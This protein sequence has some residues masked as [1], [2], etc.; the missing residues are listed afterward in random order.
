MKTLISISNL[1]ILIALSFIVRAQNLTYEW[2]FEGSRELDPAYRIPRKPKIIDTV[3]ARPEVKKDLIPVKKEVNIQ[4]EKIQAA[5]IKVTDKLDQLY[6]GYALVGVGRY[7]MPI[8]EFYYNGTRSKKYH[9]GI[10]AKHHSAWV[11]KIQDFAQP[12]F[13]RTQA[14]LYGKLIEK[15]YTVSSRLNYMNHGVLLYGTRDSLATRDS[16]RQRFQN[17]GGLVQFESHE[18]DSA[19]IN[20]RLGLEYNNYRDKARPELT[21]EWRARENY[22]GIYSNFRYK[23]DQ[24][25]Y[26]LNA[27]IQFN[28]YKFGIADSTL[29]PNITGFNVVNMMFN[30]NPHITHRSL[31]DKLKVRAGFNLVLDAYDRTIPTLAP[32]IH[33]QYALFNNHLLPYAS[34][35]GF[36]VQQNTFRSASQTNHFIRS[37]IELR[38]ERNALNFKGGIRGSISN[39]VSLDANFSVGRH[40]DKMLFVLDTSIV[41]GN[42]FKAI[43]AD[44][45]IS[46]IEVALTY[47]LLE[48]MNFDLVGQ[49]YSYQTSLVPYAWNLP[50]YVIKF[51]GHYN[52]FDEFIVNT[53]LNFLGGRKMQE[54]GPGE[55][56]EQTDLVYHSNMGLLADVNLSVEYRYNSRVSAFI[57]FN[58]L[59]A[60]QYLRWMNYPVY[61]FQA[62]GGATFRF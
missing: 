5:N 45:N 51:R 25:V 36:G 34:A 53:D 62:L 33:V 1:V 56:I 11:G 40:V 14:D 21:N 37:N 29:A 7:M 28:N 50:N 16:L 26:S 15:K 31:D 2:E 49:L 43:F 9:W 3:F 30:L 19:T 57:Q 20:W 60:Q 48:K 59:A 47:Q 22:V 8:G 41:R 17:F 55:G 52:I 32:D 58:N 24:Q 46:R 13:D 35:N 61:G 42:Q 4:V 44:M 38:N 23:L 10:E 39:S 6:P 18:K 54:F 12:Q 27:N